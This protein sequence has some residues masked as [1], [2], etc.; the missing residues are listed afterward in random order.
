MR[1]SLPFPSDAGPLPDGAAA[2]AA[3][4]TVLDAVDALAA[5]GAP[6][7]S[8]ALLGG[9]V[10]AGAGAWLLARLAPRWGWVDAPTG[11][12]AARK[13]Q[14][15]P[16]P[17]VGGPAILAGLLAGWLLWRAGASAP[18]ALGPLPGALAALLPPAPACAA[19]LLLAFLVGLLDDVL[20]GGL[21]P[22]R[23]L[24]GQALAGAPLALGLAWGAPGPAAAA[25]LALASVAAAVAAQNALNT[26]DNTDGGAGSLGVLALA[27]PQPVAAAA[28]L[29]FLPFNLNARRRGRGPAQAPPSCYLGDSGS[30]L[31]GMLILLTPPAWPALCLPLLDL[32]RL[33]VVRWRAGSRPWIGDRRHLAHRLEAAGL[34]RAGVLGGLLAVALPAV[35]LG[36]LGIVQGRPA[37][38]AAGLL[39][40]AAA[41][42][43]AVL[44]TPAPGAGA[45]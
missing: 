5:A 35:V 12:E 6:A 15:R 9:L 23:K 17:Q 18:G 13:L 39:L 24:L 19:A 25:G 14:A 44:S 26:F 21:A 43:W 40:T 2:P 42:A 4:S 22:R 41:Y 31:L 11:P 45:Q 29:G 37:P 27:A 1:L 33:S 28:L 38:L 7:A 16:V 10:A 20:P 8:L 32:G 36:G 34:G 30:H 3:A